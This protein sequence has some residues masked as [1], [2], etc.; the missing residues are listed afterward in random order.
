MDEFLGNTLELKKRRLENMV[1]LDGR[2]DSDAPIFAHARQRREFAQK[3]WYDLKTQKSVVCNDEWVNVLNTVQLY[4]TR[5]NLAEYELDK[6][7]QEMDKLKRKY[8]ELI[9]IVYL[10]V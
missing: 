7:R 3:S 1:A 8:D 6:T 4:E 5:K 2:G 9:S 10:S